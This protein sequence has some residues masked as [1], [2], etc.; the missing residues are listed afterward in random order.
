MKVARTVAMLLLF[1]PASAS[2]AAPGGTTPELRKEMLKK[3]DDWSVPQPKAG[4]KVVKIWVYRSGF[5][6]DEM[7]EDIYDRYR[8]DAT[9]RD[10]SSSDKFSGPGAGFPHDRIELRDFIACH[11]AGWLKLNPYFSDIPVGV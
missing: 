5:K 7:V 2:S 10:V 8:N 9:V 3:A 6:T 1:R 4:A 11:W